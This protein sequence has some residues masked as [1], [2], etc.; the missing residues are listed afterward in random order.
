MQPLRTNHSR[1]TRSRSS[2]GPTR[3]PIPAKSSAASRSSTRIGTCRSEPLTSISP[4]S[5]NHERTRSST[6]FGLPSC[7]FVTFV[8]LAF[9]DFQQIRDHLLVRLPRQ[10]SLHRELHFGVASAKVT[11]SWERVLESGTISTTNCLLPR[12]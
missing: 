2:S 1:K 10:N 4:E 3:K 7:T 11:K 8:V 12:R 5:I 6:K 9:I